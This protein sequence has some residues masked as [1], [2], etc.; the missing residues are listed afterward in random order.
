MS[1]STMS[2]TTF[3]LLAPLEDGAYSEEENI[4]K[5]EAGVLG[6]PP[7]SSCS[8]KALLGERERVALLFQPSQD[9]YQM[10]GH[11]LGSRAN[12]L[13]SKEK[14]Q[15]GSPA[16]LL[17]NGEHPFNFLLQPLPIPQRGSGH[18]QVYGCRVPYG[19]HW[20]RVAAQ[21]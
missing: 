21:T 14:S 11:G 18:S 17:Q 12:V 1:S 3:A 7:G 19:S 10:A 20:P 15:R 2:V 9:V 4:F 6:P 8:L 16:P 13:I 5:I